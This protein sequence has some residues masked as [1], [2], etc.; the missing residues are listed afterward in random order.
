MN[1]VLYTQQKRF[2][3]V[4]KIPTRLTLLFVC[5]DGFNVICFHFLW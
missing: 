5:F 1:F 3:I 4:P 2:I